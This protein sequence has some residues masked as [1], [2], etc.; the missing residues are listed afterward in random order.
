MVILVLFNDVERFSIH[1][2]SSHYL[3]IYTFHNFLVFI[4]WIKVYYLSRVDKVHFISQMCF[5]TQQIIRGVWI[6]RLQLCGSTS[7]MAPKRKGQWNNNATQCWLRGIE[8][9]LA[10]ARVYAIWR[11][12]PTHTHLK[13]SL[14]HISSPWRA[15][16]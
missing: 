13:K 9:F 10:L 1:W 7:I 3:L 11:P 4:T 16:E 14:R 8:E 6:R 2:Q 15:G 5:W 12:P